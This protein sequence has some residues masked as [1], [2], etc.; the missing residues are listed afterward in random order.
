M[1]KI[2]FSK[3]DEVQNYSPLPDGR[4]LCRVAEVEQATTQHGDEMWKL[5]F[6]VEAGPHRGRYIFDNMVFSEAAMKRVKLLCS[7]LDLNAA[8]ELD[9]TPALIKGRTCYLTVETEEY[10][11]G[12]GM[13]KKRNVVPF[14]GYERADE[15]GALGA[16]KPSAMSDDEDLP[17]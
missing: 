7:R 15:T 10:E 5:R 1:P 16:T 6:L 2:D 4:Y 11:D 17:F 9:L 3:V 13:T 8:G 12:E 14:A